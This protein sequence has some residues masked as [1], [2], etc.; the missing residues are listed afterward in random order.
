MD[1][2]WIGFDLDGTLAHNECGWRHDWR[3]IGQ[4][5]GPILELVKK[6]LAEGRDVRIFTARVDGNWMGEKVAVS[7]V[8][9]TIEDWCL[10]HIGKVLPITNRK[11]THMEVLFDDRAIHVERNTGRIIG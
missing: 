9:K 5:I 2:R 4:P 8:R 3:N 10:L 7:E 11:D 1:N 6:Y